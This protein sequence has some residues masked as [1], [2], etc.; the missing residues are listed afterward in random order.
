[1]GLFLM[2]SLFLHVFGPAAPLLVVAALVYPLLT[3]I[4]RS[5]R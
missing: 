3:S 4:V 1:M 5:R 2:I